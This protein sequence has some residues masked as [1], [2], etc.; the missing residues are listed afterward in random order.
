MYKLV[1]KQKK[2]KNKLYKNRMILIFNSEI[3]DL[4][5]C[6]DN[7]AICMHLFAVIS[8]DNSLMKR[9]F[10]LRSYCN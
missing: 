5:L 6:E 8:R 2:Q 3:T 9:A 10:S 1:C 4:L 7:F